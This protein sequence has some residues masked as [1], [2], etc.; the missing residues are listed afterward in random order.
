[1]GDYTYLQAVVSAVIA[2]GLVVLMLFDPVLTPVTTLFGVFFLYALSGP[3]EWAGYALLNG[4][5]R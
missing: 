4:H 2:L 3:L 1:M 5:D